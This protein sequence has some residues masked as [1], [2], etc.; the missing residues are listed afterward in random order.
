MTKTRFY[1]ALGLG[2]AGGAVA[3]AL[4]MRAGRSVD[5]YMPVTTPASVMK[6][7]QAEAI[8]AEVLPPELPDWRSRAADRVIRSSVRWWSAR[9]QELL[10][11]IRSEIR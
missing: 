2:L 4:V 6:G 9:A 7:D 3:A 10:D 5:A 1:I 8:Q 11:P